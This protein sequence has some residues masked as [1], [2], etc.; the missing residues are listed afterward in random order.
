MVACTGR[1]V[2]SLAI[3]KTVSKICPP[4]IHSPLS[5]NR[6]KTKVGMTQEIY[7]DAVEP[8]GSL[9]DCALRE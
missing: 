4:V 8:E 3:A 1:R 9:F 6:K 2:Y 5:P 7:G